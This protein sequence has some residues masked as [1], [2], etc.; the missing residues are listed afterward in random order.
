[1]SLDLYREILGR[2]VFAVTGASQNTAK[3]GY[4]IYRF[5]KN[6]GYE[7]YPVNPT[8]EEV[9]GDKCYPSLS[10]LPTKPDCVITV[11]PYPAT[12]NT[13]REAVQL[14]VPFIWMQPGSESAT[15]V[16]EGKKG[17][18]VVWGGPCVMVEYNRLS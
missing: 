11:T 16:E 5:M 3:F 8:A 1:M 15:A 7:V 2:R 13:A 4:K 6:A 17:A 12:E 18:Q 14:G 9:D 10:E